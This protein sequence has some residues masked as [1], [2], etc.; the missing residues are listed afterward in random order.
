MAPLHKDN[1]ETHSLAQFLAEAL[2]EMVFEAV[3]TKGKP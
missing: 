2:V 1:T 3:K